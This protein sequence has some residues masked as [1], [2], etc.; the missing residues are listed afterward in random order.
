MEIRINGQILDANLENEKNVGEVLAGLEQWLSNSGYV[1]SGLIIDGQQITASMVEEVF[2]REIK[3]VKTL[4]IQTESFAALAVSSFLTLL[5]D[6]TFFENLSFE[7]KTKF[8]DTWTESACGRF[9]AAEAADL[10]SLCNGTFSSG[11]FSSNELRLI[12]EERIREIKE[13]L[14]EFSDIENLLNEVCERLVDLPLDIQTGK[15][16]R[17]AQTIQV[18]T[19]ITEK[20][21]RLFKALDL[22]GYLSINDEQKGKLVEQFSAFYDILKELFDAFE[23]NDSVV[24]GDLAE[25][26]ASVR[27]KEIYTFVMENCKTNSSKAGNGQ[28]GEKND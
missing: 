26:E 18:F 28:T 4:D 7:E 1:L 13:P 22:Q 5:E 20:I 14:K 19:T 9:I 24:V 25:Y 10:F 8:Y 17:A 15:E 12:T 16:T 23:K 27:I 21:F 3:S 6:I 2:L 11:D